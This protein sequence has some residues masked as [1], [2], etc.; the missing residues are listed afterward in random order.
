M[1]MQI[2]MV[3]SLDM[4]TLV[5]G[6]GLY[7]NMLAVILIHEIIGGTDETETVD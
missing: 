7:I 2:W 5:G 6:N 4:K 1:V 3:Y